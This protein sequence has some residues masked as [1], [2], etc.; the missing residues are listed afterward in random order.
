MAKKHTL[1]TLTLDAREGAGTTKSQALRK[2]GKVPGVVYGHGDPTPV[3]VDAKQLAELLLSGNRSHIVEAMVA[4]K[5]DS[6]LIR[7]IEA[8]PLS[9]KPLSVDFQRVSQGEAITA[10]RHRDHHRRGARRERRGRGDGHRHP[11]AR[12]QGPGPV[13]PRPPR[14]RRDRAGRRTPTSPPAKSRCRRASALLTPPDTVVVSVEITRAAVAEGPAEETPPRPSRAR[15]AHGASLT[16]LDDLSMI[17]GLGNPGPQICSHAPQRG[18]HRGR[19][20]GASSGAWASATGRRKARRASRSTGRGSAILVEPQAFMNLSGPPTLGL[21]TFY[22]VPPQRMLVVVDDLDLPFGTLRMRAEGSSGGQNGLKSLIACFG[23]GFPRLR[24]GIG[25]DHEGD[26]IDRVLSEFAP[27]EAAALPALVAR[28]VEGIELWLSGGV[29]AAMNRVNAKPAKSD[30][31][32]VWCERAQM[33][34]AVNR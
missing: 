8:H 16:A 3:A 19:R 1:T 14:D 10:T 6:V 13:D 21:A 20:A 2:T 22:K 30:A 7:K 24:V 15:R 28:A 17:V 33:G 25:R 27:D 9:R 29:A 18:L 32:H 31:R 11:H 23:Q 12:R 34:D 26:A 5:P 4:G